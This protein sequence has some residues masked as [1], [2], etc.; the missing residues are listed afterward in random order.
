MAGDAAA[1]NCQV[2]IVVKSADQK[3]FDVSPRRWAVECRL[4]RLARFGSQR[5]G[6]DARRLIEGVR[7]GDRV[8][9]RGLTGKPI[10]RVGLAQSL[11]IHHI[12]RPRRHPQPE[13][14]A[15]LIAHG[16]L[17]TDLLA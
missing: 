13:I 14:R 12:R 1:N 10:L 6:L 15:W 9:S 2:E 8:C 5:Y 16:H 17:P 4:G 11:T 3:G 7:A